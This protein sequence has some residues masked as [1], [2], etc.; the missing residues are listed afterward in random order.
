MFDF[1]TFQHF[2]F[3]TLF[4]M[5][6]QVVPENF[7]PPNLVKE[8]YIAR[9]LMASDAEL[10]FAAVM[11]SIDI[12]KETR[13]GSWP[14]ANLTLEEDRIDLSWH[15]R[16]FENNSSFAYTV[17]NKDE[18]KCLGC[19]YLYPM[20]FRT[21]LGKDNSNYDIDLS[22]W[23]TQEMYNQGFYDQL[24]RDIK[25]WLEKEW[26]FKKVYFSNKVLPEGIFN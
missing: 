25:E 24:G 7:T 18:T 21:D 6:V 4:N 26:P 10:D 19:F 1:I 11:S 17:V 3:K 22:W 23:V 13:G 15:Q 9:K 2:N 5:F 8:N 16:E 14:S 20:G 12:I